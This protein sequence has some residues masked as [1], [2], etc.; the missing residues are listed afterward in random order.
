MKLFLEK[1]K[2]K[3]KRWS[4]KGV[5]WRIPPFHHDLN[6]GLLGGQLRLLL[7][8]PFLPLQFEVPSSP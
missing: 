8:Q 4:K 7:V 2:K 3:K 6:L 1:K 5:C